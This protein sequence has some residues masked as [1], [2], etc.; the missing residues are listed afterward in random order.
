MATK[1][2]H[3]CHHPDKTQTLLQEIQIVSR[4]TL[5]SR[6]EEKRGTDMDK[7]NPKVS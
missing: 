3:D 7:Q 5:S 6:F 2:P 1:S 4:H